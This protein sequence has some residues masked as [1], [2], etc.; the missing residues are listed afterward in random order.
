MYS[1][2]DRKENISKNADDWLVKDYQDAHSSR[3]PAVVYI[4]TT[5][6]I[7]L[8]IFYHTCVII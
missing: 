8:F 6:I 3:K 4:G 7:L 5:A 2:C 1:P